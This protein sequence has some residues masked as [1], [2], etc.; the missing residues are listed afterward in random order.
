MRSASLLIAA[1]LCIGAVAQAAALPPPLP[2]EHLKVEPLAAAGPHRI[3]VFDDAFFNE[4]DTRVYVFDGDTYRR[5]GQI[6]T[7]YFSAVNISPDGKTTVAAT[8]YFSR[9][10]RGTR[11]DVVEFHDNSTLTP[12]R[13]IVLPA[14]RAMTL[15]TFFGVAYSDDAH[16][17]YASY[18]TPAASFGVLDPQAG[19][20]WARSTPPV[21]SWSF[22]QDLTGCPRS[23]RAG[24]C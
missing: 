18:I 22:P 8:T 11:T 23:A 20:Y 21:A 12:I 2:A 13:E 1:A 9:G 10:S 3:Y 24:A 17:V 5:L 15:P 7:G 6:D 14:K 4:T 19:K 16:F